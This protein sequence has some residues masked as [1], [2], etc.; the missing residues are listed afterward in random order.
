MS[1]SWDVVLTPSLPFPPSVCSGLCFFCLHTIGKIT[2]ILNTESLK[3]KKEIAIARIIQL[4]EG[5]HQDLVGLFEIRKRA[6]KLRESKKFR[7]LQRADI[8]NPPRQEDKELV[9]ANSK[10]GFSHEQLPLISSKDRGEQTTLLS[11]AAWFAFKKKP[12]SSPSSFARQPGIALDFHL[13]PK[14]QAG[15]RWLGLMEQHLPLER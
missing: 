4:R 8:S 12:L 2:H 3:D 14:L 11:S 6:G 9:V 1:M 13:H 15:G 7:G 10:Y 5:K